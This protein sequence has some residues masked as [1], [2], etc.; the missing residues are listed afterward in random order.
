MRYQTRA[1]VVLCGVSAIVAVA[2]ALAFVGTGRAAGTNICGDGKC[3]VE[4]LAPHSLAA[5]VT[6]VSLTKFTNEAS[7][8][9][10]ATHTT[11]SVTFSQPV[12]IVSFQLVVNG[13]LL[14]SAPTC[15]QSS[16]GVSCSDFGSTLGGS[17]DKLIVQYSTTNGAVTATAQ[18]TFGEQNTNG[19]PKNDRFTSTDTVNVFNG[20]AFG[21]QCKNDNSTNTLN[22]G[23][24]SLTAS[25]TY[26]AGATE[27]NASNGFLPC[28]PVSAGVI[29]GSKAVNT[30]VAVVDF[31]A[32]AAANCAK[33]P[34]SGNTFCYALS[35]LNFLSGL[36]KNE[37]ANNFVLYEALVSSGLKFDSTKI[38]VPPCDATTG[39]PPSPGAPAT[40]SLNDSCVAGTSN[41]S[42][43]GVRVQLHALASPPDQNYGG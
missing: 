37:N 33:D 4:T 26:V 38:V 22:G 18:V 20:T 25:L 11:M 3:L 35:T 32:A 30:E 42:K 7:G 40:S 14:P 9:A 34:V 17:F 6:G 1:I 24:S 41:L 16:T 10:T 19:V 15:T 27:A 28:T 12:T 13:T 21:S 8:G 31:P 5:G 43:G 23:D 29:P 2:A 39:L 36:P